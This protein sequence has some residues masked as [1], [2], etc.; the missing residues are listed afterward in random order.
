MA[1]QPSPLVLLRDGDQLA[2]ISEVDASDLLH[3][4]SP[5]LSSTS[6]SA[7]QS[8]VGGRPRSGT[9]PD[10]AV[11]TPEARGR[12]QR[13]SNSLSERVRSNSFSPL[14]PP[15]TLVD[16]APLGSGPLFDGR[17]RQ[18]NEEDLRPPNT[19][20]SYTPQKAVSKPR[21]LLQVGGKV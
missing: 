9:N 19:R 20:H 4:N 21:S 1:Q 12:R 10:E 16:S 7:P 13:S 11:L 15:K 8:P 6:R 5:P 18:A 14:P 17:P 3:A 2:E